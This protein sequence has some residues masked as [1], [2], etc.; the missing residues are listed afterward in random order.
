MHM[1]VDLLDDVGDVGAGEH[2]VL[3][4]P[5]EAPELSQISNRRPESGRDLGLRVHGHRDRFAVYHGSVLKDVES[6]LALSEKESIYLMLYEDPQKMVKM[7]DVL[8]GE[9]SLER[10]Y[11]V[12]QECCAGCG[13]YNI[14]NIEQQVYRIGA[15]AEDE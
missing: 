10:R 13:E 9:F 12:L 3:E 15:V 1:E 8:H 6:N 7:A 2:Q 11:G 14:I 4:G 5:G